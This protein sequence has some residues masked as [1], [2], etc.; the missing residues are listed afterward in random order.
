V[1]NMKDKTVNIRK[2]EE[3]DRQAVLDLLNLGFKK[4]QRTSTVRGN[5]FW[6]WKYNAGIFGDSIL[7]LAECNERIVGVGNLWPW[8]LQC[9]GQILKGL[10]ACD[11]VIHPEFQGKGLFKAI[12]EYG[13]NIA[14][15]EGFQLI[16]NFPNRNS[17]STYQS[18]GWDYLGL[19][20]WWVK[21]LEPVNTAVSYF[22][23]EKASGININ[24]RFVLDICKLIEVA[25]EYRTYDKFVDV[26]RKREFY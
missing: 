3:G 18:L 10:Q 8:E 6:Q 23:D 16:Y 24:K 12:R 5:K 19:I 13:L 14:R 15:K 9:R 1:K 20:P 17:L 4:E 25:S 2:A 22:A 21:I 7:T 11:S 26:N